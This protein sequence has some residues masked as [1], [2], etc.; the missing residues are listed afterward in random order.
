MRK[1]FF[2]VFG[3]LIFFCS[4]SEQEGDSNNIKFANK[5]IYLK[6]IPDY[7]D[8]VVIE[9]SSNYVCIRQDEKSVKRSIGY[10]NKTDV[11]MESDEQGRPFFLQCKDF[12]SNIS[13]KGDTVAL[14]W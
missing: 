12:Q 4:C 1:L 9:N 5:L 8:E 14:L 11:L 7:W 10:F 13:Y 6:N 2:I 3:L